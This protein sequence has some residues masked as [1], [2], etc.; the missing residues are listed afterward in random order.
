MALP[1]IEKDV[2]REK[3]N[4]T[5]A[6]AWNQQISE[7]QSLIFSKELVELLET[8]VEEYEQNQLSRAKAESY[9]TKL[10]AEII[11]EVD[12][13]SET[14]KSKCFYLVLKLKKFGFK[15]EQELISKVSIEPSKS[16]AQEWWL[17]ALKLMGKKKQ[18]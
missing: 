7:L 12:S 14:N 5:R 11:K 18:V 15:I 9:W 3:M 1:I 2:S 16:Q 13:W 4:R 10:Q 6:K 8:L 17:K